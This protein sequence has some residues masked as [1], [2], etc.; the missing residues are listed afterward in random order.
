[1]QEYLNTPFLV[2]GLKFDMRLYVL[3]MSADPLKIFLHKEG[4]VRFA[5]QNYQPI[6]V[7]NS[8]R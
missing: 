2:D 3:V 4:L 1:M 5:T 8:D 6:Q 7:G